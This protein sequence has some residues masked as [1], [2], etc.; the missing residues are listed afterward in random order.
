MIGKDYYELPLPEEVKDAVR[1]ILENPKAKEELRRIG[2]LELLRRKGGE[3]CRVE[4]Q[5]IPRLEIRRGEEVDA[6]ALAH[7]T[8]ALEAEGYTGPSSI[9][10]L[11]GGR[12]WIRGFT[13]DRVGSGLGKWIYF[14]FDGERMIGNVNGFEWTFRSE[15]EKR[16]LL[17]IYNLPDKRIGHV[18]VHIH[19]EYLDGEVGA[20]LMQVAID[21]AREIGIEILSM[22]TWSNN[23]PAIQIAEKAGFEEHLRLKK[24]D[25][26]GLGRVLKKPMVFMTIEIR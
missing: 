11:R 5:N 6:D 3:I 7:L 15:K 25:S 23:K 17:D 1:D 8:D 10:A 21:E 26:I 13:V 12:E 22:N 18:G 4:S 14:A 16:E 19:P 20:T 2:V 24:G 9:R